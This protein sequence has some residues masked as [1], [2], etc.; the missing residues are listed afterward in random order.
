MSS[1]ALARPS[2]IPSVFDDFFK[3]W[4]QWFDDG[5]LVN[6]VTNL[7]AVN[8]KENGNHYTVSLAAPGM[9]KEDFHIDVNGNMITISSER[10]QSTEDKGDRYTRQEY[11]YSSFSR[12]F[13]VPDDVKPE[14]IDARY[15]NGELKITLPRKEDT[16]KTMATKRIAV[17]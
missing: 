9:K 15:E 10:E 13:T 1:K 5:G 16:K 12:S 3:P 2:A 17:K 14:A 8:I 7:P 6:R 4:S 11:S